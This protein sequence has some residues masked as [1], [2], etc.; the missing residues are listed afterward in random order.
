GAMVNA[1]TMT[2]TVATFDPYVRAMFRLGEQSQIEY[3]A[4]SAVPPIRF[5]RDYAELPDPTPRVTLDHDRARLERARHQEL[6]YSDNLTPN[7]TLT[8]A[9]FDEH[10][11]RAAVNGSF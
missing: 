5:N 7:D 10:F 9:V 1:V 11:R 6:L 8:A 2:D 4:A 3:R